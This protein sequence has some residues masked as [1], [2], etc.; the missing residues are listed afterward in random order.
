MTD[1]ENIPHIVA[2]VPSMPD[3]SYS[4]VFATD[5]CHSS[6]PAGFINGAGE[7]AEKSI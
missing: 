1:W 4:T 3:W 5:Q 2:G 7:R 6:L